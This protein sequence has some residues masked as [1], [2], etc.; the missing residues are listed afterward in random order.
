MSYFFPCL[1]CNLNLLLLIS[2]HLTIILLWNC[3]VAIICFY[4]FLWLLILK[5]NS[6]LDTLMALL[7]VLWNSSQLPPRLPAIILKFSIL[8]IVYGTN[9][10]NSFWVLSSPLYLKPYLLVLLVSRLIMMSSTFWRK[11]FP[12]NLKLAL[13]RLGTN[14]PLSRRVPSQ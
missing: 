12:L 14:L 6:C 4:T 1:P 5:D 8:N 10:T 9:K 7:P 2:P 11:C 13:C 3:P